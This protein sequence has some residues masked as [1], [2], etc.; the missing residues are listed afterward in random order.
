VTL[1]FPSF[2]EWWIIQVPAMLISVLLGEFMCMQAETQDI[3]LGSKVGSKTT[4]KPSC[5]EL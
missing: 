3:S 4:S 2:W 1:G 5:E